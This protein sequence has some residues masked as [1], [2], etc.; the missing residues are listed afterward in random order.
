MSTSDIFNLVFTLFATFAV[1]IIIAT[2]EGSRLFPPQQVTPPPTGTTPSTPP[3]TPTPT[4]KRSLLPLS[5]SLFGVCVTVVVLE[6]LTAIMRGEDSYPF[7]HPVFKAACVAIFFF[8]IW[9]WVSVQ[10]LK[11]LNWPQRRTLILGVAL[12]FPAIVVSIY[13]I[14]AQTHAHRIACQPTEVTKK[15]YY[16]DKRQSV[17]ERDGRLFDLIEIEQDGE[18]TWQELKFEISDDMWD[19]LVNCNW[20]LTFIHAQSPALDKKKRQPVCSYQYQLTSDETVIVG[21][22]M[23]RTHCR[24]S[25]QQHKWRVEVETS[26]SST[27]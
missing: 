23:S 22:S 2:I 20:H 1:E 7:F 26:A 11:W 24:A 13:Y 14:A 16:G 21:Y 12:L 6:T 25:S 3:P 10:S 4:P 17:K 15:I 8:G 19:G 27:R 9:I 5:R 18:T